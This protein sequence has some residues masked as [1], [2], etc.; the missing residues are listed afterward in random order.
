MPVQEYKHQLFV[1]IQE[2]L[3]RQWCEL[4]IP[5]QISTGKNSETVL[6]PEALLLFSAKFARYDQRLYD[7]ILEW[8]GVHSCQINIQ[9]L[10]AL[11]AKAECK[12]TQSLGYIAAVAAESEPSRWKKPAKDYSANC[13][14]SA[15]A[16][17]RSQDDEPESFIPTCDSLAI[18]Y[19]LERNVRLKLGKI[20]SDIPESTSSLL[21]RMRSIM[22]ITAR[23]ETILF[24]LTNNCCKVQD[25]VERSGYT[26]KSIQDVLQE[27]ASGYFVSSI[28]GANRGRQ[29]YL[30]QPERIRQ[31]FGIRKIAFPNWLDIYDS[32]GFLWETLSNPNMEK[33]SE[34]TFQNELK[35]L[36][37][38]KIQ[39]RFL[40]SGHPAIIKQAIDIAVLPKTIREVV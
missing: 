2:L 7:L 39:K 36:Y 24:M 17:F 26:W 4:G 22:G 14:D 27:L 31:L 23:A 35:T 8:M 37:E 18:L 21:F 16:L 25:I 38:N 3:W 12:D 6:D 40:M 33:V 15:V 19:G 11:H 34:E 5:G 30:L 29:Y 1:A 20:P 32:I 28:N 10:R 13:S 9:R